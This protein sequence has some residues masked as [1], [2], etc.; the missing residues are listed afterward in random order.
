MEDGVT[1]LMAMNVQLLIEIMAAVT[2]SF[3]GMIQTKVF[4]NMA[5]ALVLAATVYIVTG[6]KDA[7]S[8]IL[9]IA[10]GKPSFQFQ[11]NEFVHP[12]DDESVSRFYVVDGK[13]EKDLNLM[14]KLFHGRVICS[15][16][17]GWHT[18]K[19]TKDWG[20]NTLTL[21]CLAAMSPSC[22]MNPIAGSC[23]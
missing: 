13:S 11:F 2:S 1:A 23:T 18:S 19:L 10:D 5:R 12:F 20:Q 3:E 9:V 17:Q 15:M 16:S 8:A 6:C 22:S 21:F 7:Q 14:N 4:T